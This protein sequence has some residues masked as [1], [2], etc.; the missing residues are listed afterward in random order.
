MAWIIPE[1]LQSQ[2]LRT[3]D[4]ASS[5]PKAFEGF[6]SNHIFAI[7]TGIR[8]S[9]Q[10]SQSMR[11]IM[12]SPVYQDFAKFN[13]NN[14]GKPLISAYGLGTDTIS[15]IDTVC[16]LNDNIGDLTG[17]T[18]Y[19]F[20]SSYGGLCR[21]VLLQY[22]NVNSYHCID[23][24]Q[25]QSLQQTYFKNIGFQSEKVSYQ[26]PSTPIDVFISESG[27]TEQDNVLD[28]WTKYGAGTPT[29]LI[30]SNMYTSN[31]LDELVDLIT[32]THDLVINQPLRI[33][34][35]INKLI[36]AKKKV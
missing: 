12:S 22:P 31:K 8:I 27:I 21:C 30:K 26:E 17:K 34:P 18:I 3:C 36:L 20:G 25:V 24:P 19:E 28:L 32:Q 35:N 33:Q 23:L 5:I 6:R 2:Y 13:D 10:A 4:L 7:P 15:F 1:T 11:R 9:Y 29:A 14:V 16:L